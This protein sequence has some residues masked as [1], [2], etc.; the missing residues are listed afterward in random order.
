MNGIDKNKIKDKDKF[1]KRYIKNRG[2]AISKKTAQTLNL[3][4]SMID[5]GDEYF[6]LAYSDNNNFNKINKKIIQKI[7]KLNKNFKTFND[8]RLFIFSTIRINKDILKE[9]LEYLIKKS[10]KN[11]KKYNIIYVLSLNKLCIF[12]LKNN[13]YA[14]KELDKEIIYKIEE[15][16]NKFVGE[17]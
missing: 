3:T 12:D 10:N 17:N 2:Y 15:N 4:H 14:Y 11:D 6:Y 1:R 16:V 7:E 13:N 9:E 8:N 5:I